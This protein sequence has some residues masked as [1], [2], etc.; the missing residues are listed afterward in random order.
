MTL[1]ASVQLGR[2]PRVKQL[3]WR[4]FQPGGLVGR[5]DRSRD[6]RRRGSP[7]RKREQHQMARHSTEEM[8]HAAGHYRPTRHPRAAIRGAVRRLG[9]VA[10]NRRALRGSTAR[11]LS[12]VLF[13]FVVTIPIFALGL[14]DQAARYS[15]EP[16]DISQQAPDAPN[17]RAH[18]SATRAARRSER[19]GRRS[20]EGLERRTRREPIAVPYRSPGSDVGNHR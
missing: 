4:V 8:E 20:S 15:L 7:I 6:R 13:L 3:D 9:D 19:R 17:T 1:E 16:N 11:A 18:R 10:R 2:A 5:V 12:A 14:W